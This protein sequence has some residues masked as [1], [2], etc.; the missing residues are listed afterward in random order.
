ME[1]DWRHRNISNRFY[2]FEAKVYE[3]FEK[4]A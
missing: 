2:Y 1:N 3:L 4:L